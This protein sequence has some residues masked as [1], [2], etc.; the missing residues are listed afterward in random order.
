MTWIDIYAHYSPTGKVYVGQSALGMR[1][2]WTNHL[3]DARRGSSAP[4]HRA[5]RRY[6]A[7]AFTHKLLDRV[8]TEAAA[9]QAERL[10]I[11]EL[12]ALGPRGY[13][14]TSG[15]EGASGGS[16]SAQ[17]RARMSAAHKGRVFSPEHRERI[18]A[19]LR[20]RP[21]SPEV[22]AKCS[23]ALLGR[24]GRPHSQETKDKIRAANTG[25]RRP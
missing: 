5:I 22:R 8:R 9:H 7:G 16:P 19:A 23:A 2:R 14:A 12:G 21:R 15:G 13:N 24:P 4:F 1:R 20:G 3:A 10:W 11:Q 17:A 6:G 25:R 18:A